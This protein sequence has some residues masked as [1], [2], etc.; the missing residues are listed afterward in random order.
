M[1][2]IDKFWAADYPTGR[3]LPAELQGPTTSPLSNLTIAILPSL[4]IGNDT[5]EALG[6]LLATDARFNVWYGEGIGKE[7][8]S[9][10][11]L[12]EI[13]AF[14]MDSI[15]RV[16]DAWVAHRDNSSNVAEDTYANLLSTLRAEALSMCSLMKVTFADFGDL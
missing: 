8:P 7:N 14:S 13:R 4:R 10:R 3:P 5:V 2:G 9:G 1:S 16:H 6:L 15:G 12:A 11:E